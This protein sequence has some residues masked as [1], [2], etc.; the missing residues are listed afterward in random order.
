MARPKKK[1]LEY[2]T[3]DVNFYQDIKIR[4]LIRHKGIQSVSVYHILLCQIYSNG[5]FIHWDEDLP[6]ILSEVS[7]LEEDKIIEANLKMK[8]YD[9]L[10]KEMESKK[11]ELLKILK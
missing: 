8:E 9:S 3:N 4:K 10:I 7:G 5:Y 11:K 2:F 1:G 6:F